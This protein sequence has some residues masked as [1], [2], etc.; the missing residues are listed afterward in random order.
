MSHSETN[1][2]AAEKWSLQDSDA[3]RKYS[4][5]AK[6]M[7]SVNISSLDENQKKKLIERHAEKLREDVCT[8]AVYKHS[9][10]VLN[11]YSYSALFSPF[12]NKLP[13]LMGKRT[14]LYTDLSLMNLQCIII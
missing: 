12:L 9:V 14:K 8:L 3:K 1:K 5:T 7:S 4:D 6:A 11:H 10:L 2:L 13:S